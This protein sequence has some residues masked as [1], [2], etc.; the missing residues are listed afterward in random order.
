M[1]TA[2][3]F[4]YPWVIF[5]LQKTLFGVSAEFVR[6]MVNT[7]RAASV[8]HTPDFM[9][10]VINLR[11]VVVPLIDLRAR[12]GMSSFLSEVE[13]FCSLMDQREEDHKNWLVELE[14][15]V[16]ENRE[17]SLATD[18][19]KCAFGKWFDTFKPDSYALSMLMK[20]FDN[21]HKKIHG[22][23][24]QVLSLEKNGDLNGAL[25]I[26]EQCRENELAEMVSLFEK[27]RKNYRE[28]NNEVSVVLEVNNNLFA[29]AVDT[30]ESVESLTEGS[31]ESAPDTY[32]GNLETEL[33]KY[34]GRRKK[35][36]EVVFILDTDMIVAGL[37]TR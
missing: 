18:P 19:H 10:G 26:I 2:G 36:G 27:A 30:I 13:D 29:F 8:P 7:P 21:P 3:S 28:N 37:V 34:T 1:S 35:D 20:K 23:A 14:A 6:S 32:G 12:L 25:K 17:F 16:Q 31:I 5:T 9:R 15:A 24:T 11:G 33:V 4:G 22:I